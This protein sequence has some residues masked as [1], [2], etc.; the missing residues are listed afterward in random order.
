MKEDYITYEYISINVESDL[1]P[2][3]V[4]CYENFGWIHIKE[5]SKQ[6]YYINANPNQDIVNLKFKRDRNIKNKDELRTLQQKCEA[7]FLEVDRLEGRPQSI[8]TMYSL[9]IGTIAAGFIAISVFTAIKD[10]WIIAI[11]CGIVGLIGCIFPYPIY[12]KVI[13]KEE[14]ENKNKIDEQY[15][16]INNA[17]KEAREILLEDE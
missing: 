7:A 15:D 8:A 5:S 10:I 13:D 14:I 6:D 16:I 17:Y 1:E 3:Y 9:I 4:D 2:R 11:L 12:K